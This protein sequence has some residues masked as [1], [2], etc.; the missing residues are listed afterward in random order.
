MTQPKQQ[1][2]TLVVT[3]ALHLDDV[4]HVI[5]SPGRYPGKRKQFGIPARSEIN[6][7]ESEY[8]LE[9]SADQ[10]K[11][12]ARVPSASILAIEYDVT[13]FVRRGQIGVE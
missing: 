8:K 9:L 3:T 7:T 6:W 4:T 13:C 1:D 11:R 12:M 2:V 5:L 10:I